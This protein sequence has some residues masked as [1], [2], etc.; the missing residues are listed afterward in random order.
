MTVM[1]AGGSDVS[2]KCLFTVNA[3]KQ[4]GLTFK[5]EKA[6]NLNHT[7]SYIIL[8]LFPQESKGTLVHASREAR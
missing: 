7:T 4:K 8:Y 2:L 1:M 6:R 3:V 5:S